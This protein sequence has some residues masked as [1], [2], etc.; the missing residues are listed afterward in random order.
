MGQEQVK[1][2]ENWERTVQITARTVTSY[3]TTFGGTSHIT[4]PARIRQACRSVSSAALGGHNTL[5]TKLPLSRPSARLS[6][7]PQFVRLSLATSAFKPQPGIGHQSIHV[8]CSVRIPSHGLERHTTYSDRGLS[9]RLRPC[10]FEYDPTRPIPSS[11]TH[12]G[13][14]EHRRHR[15]CLPLGPPAPQV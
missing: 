10:Q 11:W 5:P 8:T 3:S 15:P 7:S 6:P 9:Q 12:L 4:P 1:N 13:P 14:V 2:W